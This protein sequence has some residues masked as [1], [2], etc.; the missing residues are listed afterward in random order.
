MEHHNTS[1][2]TGVHEAITCL[3][4]WDKAFGRQTCQGQAWDRSSGTKSMTRHEAIE[5]GQSQGKSYIYQSISILYR[6]ISFFL[7]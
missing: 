7:V 4:V 1:A 5:V 6:D 2:N 3:F